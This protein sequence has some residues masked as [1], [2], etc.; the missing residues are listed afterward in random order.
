MEIPG[1]KLLMKVPIIERVVI[2][3]LIISIIVIGISVHSCNKLV[4]KEGGVRQ[5][6][7]NIGKE[8]KSI[9]NDIAKE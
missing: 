4:S 8:V 9:K 2:M 5:I 7:V 3:I 1:K 6:I